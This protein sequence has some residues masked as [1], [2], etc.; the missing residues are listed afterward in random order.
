MKTREAGDKLLATPDKVWQKLRCD[1][2][3]LPYIQIENSEVIP[4]RL[5][6]GQRINHHMIYSM[7]PRGPT[8]VVPTRLVRHIYYKGTVIFQDANADFELKPGR[9][10]VDAFVTVSDKAEPGI[11]SLEIELNT[12]KEK[13][14]ENTN[15]VVVEKAKEIEDGEEDK[16]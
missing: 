1:Q 10:S 16:P 9:W 13:M 8:E 14:T 3:D 5:K 6:A 15:F 12:D 11:Y 2:R 7:C 4:V